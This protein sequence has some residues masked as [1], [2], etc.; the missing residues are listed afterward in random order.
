MWRNG[1]PTT[2]CEHQKQCDARCRFKVHPFAR[3]TGTTCRYLRAGAMRVACGWVGEDAVL[4]RGPTPRRCSNELW[5]GEVSGRGS[6]WFRLVVVPVA[7][8]LSPPAREDMKRMGLGKADGALRRVGALA[9]VA[10]RSA[11]QPMPDKQHTLTVRNYVLNL[12]LRRCSSMECSPTPGKAVRPYCQGRD[13]E[14]VACCSMN[15]GSKRS[16]LEPDKEAK[17]RGD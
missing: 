8:V 13:V 2:R 4:G 16:G 14:S 10:L 12:G 9:V 7:L 1:P 5:S 6:S 15:A 11:V 17:L 3:S